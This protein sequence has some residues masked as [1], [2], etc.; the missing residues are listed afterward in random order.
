MKKTAIITGGSRG[1]GFGIAKQLVEDGYT[2][3]ILDKNELKDYHENFNQ[4]TAINPDC[5]YYQGSITDKQEREEF[6]SRVVERY[7]RIDVLVNN[8]GVAPKVRMD[9]LEMTEES[10]DYVVGTNL[11]GTMFMTQLVARQMIQ[12]PWEGE[13]RG[14]II[15]IGSASTTVSSTNRGEYCMSKAGVFMLTTLFADRLAEEGI[16]VHEVRPGVIDT[17]M[18]K[19]VHEKY[20][21]MIEEGLF[22]IKRWGYPEDIGNVVSLMCSDRFVYTTGNYVDVDGGFHIRKM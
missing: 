19:V 15:N 16:L 17:D 10:F 8:A 18:T 22:P 20:S 21:R 3:A 2:A 1:I 6:V 13:K 12:Q 7:G 4:L 14:T 11:R 5:M 9:I